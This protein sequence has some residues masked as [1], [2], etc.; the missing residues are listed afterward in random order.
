MYSPTLCIGTDDGSLA[1]KDLTFTLFNA[2]SG[3]AAG[4]DDSTYF[5]INKLDSD[6][7]TATELK[8]SQD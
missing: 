2:D 3:A 5:S 6:G 4:S 8:M 1:T 7:N